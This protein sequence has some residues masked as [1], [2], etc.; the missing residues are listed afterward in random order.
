VGQGYSVV[1]VKESDGEM[2]LKVR[3][4]K[5]IFIP[6]CAVAL[7]LGVP[8][9]AYTV[10]NG[11]VTVYGQVLNPQQIRVPRSNYTWNELKNFMPEILP[12]AQSATLTAEQVCDRMHALKGTYATQAESVTHYLIYKM[13]FAVN[14]GKVSGSPDLALTDRLMS[15]SD[16]A[17][18]ELMNIYTD[19]GDRAQLIEAKE[20]K[21]KQLAVIMLHDA[22]LDNCQPYA[23]QKGYYYLTK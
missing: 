3:M 17:F 15:S 7:F 18:N 9:I 8:A 21:L 19:E 23:K 1:N 12:N 5:K 20:R 4:I 11:P 2:D 13:E 6:L 14:E 10:P 16:R 22:A